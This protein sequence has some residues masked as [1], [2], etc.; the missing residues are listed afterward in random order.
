MR[1]FRKEEPLQPHLTKGCLGIEGQQIKMPSKGGKLQFKSHT[2]KF[3]APFV[4]YADFECLTMEHS[5]TMSKPTDASKSYTEITNTKSHGYTIN[6]LN[7]I[8]NDTE[9]FLYR[10]SDC[11]SHFVRTCRTIRLQNH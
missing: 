9:S 3:E 5:S 10:G 1:G 4:M 7:S 11:M 8:T 6:V 2:R